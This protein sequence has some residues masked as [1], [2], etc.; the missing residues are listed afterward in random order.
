L[1]AQLRRL[2]AV[3]KLIG[4]AQHNGIIGAEEAASLAG[5]P[6]LSMEFPAT[7][8]YATG[9]PVRADA[10]FPCHPRISFAT[11]GLAVG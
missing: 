10:L 6:N 8:T 11:P 1:Q 4:E 5:V 9:F 7:G 2:S 3:R